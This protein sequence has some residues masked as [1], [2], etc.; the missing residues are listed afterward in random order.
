MKKHNFLPSSYDPNK[1]DIFAGIS[2]GIHNGPLCMDCGE[3]E[4]MH[5]DEDFVDSECLAEIEYKTDLEINAY[6][7]GFRA[8][9][10]VGYDDG[11]SEASYYTD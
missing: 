5:C 4:C 8:G 6:I 3:T 10:K 9:R 2:S 7:E 1:M 11:H